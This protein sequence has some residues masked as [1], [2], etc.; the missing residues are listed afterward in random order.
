[1]PL[2]VLKVGWGAGDGKGAGRRRLEAP[3]SLG[4]RDGDPRQARA[5]AQPA[6]C[7]AASPLRQSGPRGSCPV[8]YL[9]GERVGQ[10]SDSPLIQQ[11]QR[12][13]QVQEVLP[14]W[15]QRGGLGVGTG[16]R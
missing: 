15:S 4:G 9:A 13:S 12:P 7:C 14:R 16:E 6:S 10:G 1:M 2:L 3:V 5:A 11:G 8:W